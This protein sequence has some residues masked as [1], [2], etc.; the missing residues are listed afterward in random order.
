[1]EDNRM[2]KKL[3]AVGLLI[4]TLFNV[5]MATQSMEASTTKNFLNLSVRSI[6]GTDDRTRVTDTT[7]APYNSM[8]FIAADGV[9]GSVAVIGKNTVLTAAHVVK[10][11]RENP[12]KSSIYVIPGRDGSN[13]SYG[14]FKIKSIHIPQSYINKPNANSD[15]AVLTIEPLNNKSI[16]EV[17]PILSYRLTNTV[18]EGTNLITT[19]FPGDKPW[20]TM[21]TA[22]GVSLNQT[23]AR[24]FYTMDTAG[25]QSGSPVYNLDNEII[26]VHTNGGYK[27][28]FGIKIN[29]EHYQFITENLS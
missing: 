14:K 4:G 2:K 21:W 5:F 9:P 12:N 28:N 13:Y 18:A 20:G 15:I 19:G 25:G 8:T 11:I 26:A 17:V 24:L 29:S 3:I 10:N 16:G 1:M 23:S 6:I 22:K 27:K 7:Q